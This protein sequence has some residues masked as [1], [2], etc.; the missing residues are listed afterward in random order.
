METSSQVIKSSVLHR[1]SKQTYKKTIVFRQFCY[2]TETGLGQT[3][4]KLL[5]NINENLGSCFFDDNL[6][7]FVIA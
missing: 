3:I 6:F 1:K 7:F 2:E 5:L 4:A